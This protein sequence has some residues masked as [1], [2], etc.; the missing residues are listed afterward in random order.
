MLL[1]RVQERLLTRVDDEMGTVLSR[2]KASGK[3]I[4]EIIRKSGSG[5]HLL[6]ILLVLVVGLGVL[7]YFAFT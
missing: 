6:V 5:W 1:P 3:K 7:A 4:K 2:L